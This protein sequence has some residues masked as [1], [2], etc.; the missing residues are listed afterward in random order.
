[1]G[2]YVCPGSIY[3]SVFLVPIGCNKNNPTDGCSAV[4]QVLPHSHLPGLVAL[5][6]PP[7]VDPDTMDIPSS[8]IGLE[9]G[10]FPR[11]L[12]DFALV[13]PPSDDTDGA[14]DFDRMRRPAWIL[15]VLAAPSTHGH[16]PEPTALLMSNRMSPPASPSFS[17]PLEALL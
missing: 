15:G 2:R 17:L 11:P 7:Q 9:I 16:L 6:P 13:D 4:P 3:R 8:L 5:F 12:V 14:G 10:L 1:M